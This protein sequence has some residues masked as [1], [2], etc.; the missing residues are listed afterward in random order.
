[1]EH[2]VGTTMDD[3][4]AVARFIFHVWAA[5]AL[6]S[7]LLRSRS[8]PSKWVLGERQFAVCATPGPNR[9]EFA[10]VIRHGLR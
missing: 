1:V 7:A 8:Q 5:D 3:D 9:A 6:A 4:H 2:H 10:D